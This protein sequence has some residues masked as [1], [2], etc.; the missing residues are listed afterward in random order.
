LLLQALGKE[1][2]P[3]LEGGSQQE[4]AGLPGKVKPKEN[5]RKLSRMRSKEAALLKEPDQQFLHLSNVQPPP[6]PE[7]IEPSKKEEGI[8]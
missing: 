4:T 3:K 1:I 7:V 6:F 2:R 8:G 5:R